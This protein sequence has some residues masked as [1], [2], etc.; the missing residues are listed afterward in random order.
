M[1][2]DW[3]R[4]RPNPMAGVPIGR[5]RSG[6]SMEGG[7]CGKTKADIGM[8]R[9]ASSQQ[10]LGEGHGARSFSEPPT[11]TNLPHLDFKL[12][13]YRTG[14]QHIYILE[15][16][17]VSGTYYGSPRKPI[18]AIMLACWYLSAFLPTLVGTLNGKSQECLLALPLGSWTT[19]AERFPSLSRHVHI[20][21]RKTLARVAYPD[22]TH[23]QTPYSLS[24]LQTTCS[25]ILL[26]TSLKSSSDWLTVLHNLAFP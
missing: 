20:Y 6:H 8:P 1:R 12:L 2:S 13:F 16:H 3:V 4:A 10:E 17:P 14:R 9:V 26:N 21:A 22:F 5:G 11:G 18:Q 23:L 25:I 19:Q 7:C 24:Y 15:R